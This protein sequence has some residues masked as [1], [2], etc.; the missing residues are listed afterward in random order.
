MDEMY[1]NGRTYVHGTGI[2]RLDLAGAAGRIVSQLSH[3]V[4]SPCAV[5]TPNAEMIWRCANDTKLNALINSG[6]INVP[7]GIGTVWAA[8]RLGSPLPG[9]V[10]GIELGE[11]V[12]SQCAAN[13]IRVYLLGGRQGVAATAAARLSERYAGLNIA[14]TH[15]G[16]FDLNG[17]PNDSVIEDINA[18]APELLIVC[19][20]FPRQEEWILRN[21]G[22]LHGVRVIMA[23]GGSLDVWAGEV[24][25]APAPVRAAGLEWMWRVMSEPS[26]IRRAA[27]LPAFVVMTLRGGRN[28]RRAAQYIVK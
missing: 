22:R 25:R 7:D 1:Y 4:V 28:A 6:D 17:E 27:A 16:Y 21:R 18:A 9:R 19:L 14:G 23:L 26:R 5:F 11:A 10:P 12:L 8:K 15:H 20:G 2:D 3:T 13:G 24:R